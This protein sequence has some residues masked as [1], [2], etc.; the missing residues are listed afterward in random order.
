M[1]NLNVFFT[2]G[3]LTPCQIS[4]LQ[5]R[6]LPSSSSITFSYRC[7]KDGSYEEV[8]CQKYGVCWC[9]DEDGDEIPGTRSSSV[10]TC[11]RKGNSS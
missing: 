9:V 8:Q 2:G 10:I 7:K 1:K 6:V 4:A 5:E 3:V 11:P